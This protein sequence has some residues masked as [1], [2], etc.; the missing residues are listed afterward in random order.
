MEPNLIKLY[1][2]FIPYMEAVALKELGFNEPCFGTI[3]RDEDVWSWTGL[4]GNCNNSFPN[5]L[6]GQVAAPLYQQ[7]FEFFREKYNLHG[8]VEMEGIYESGND[9]ETFFYRYK[10]NEKW[11]E[12]KD[13]DEDE[14][15]FGFKHI[16]HGNKFRSY[17]E[18]QLNCLKH[19]IKSLEK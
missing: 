11:A 1:Q 12:G 17:E 8:E 3:G 19:L 5:H 9:T 7:A 10:I 13:F 16:G 2:Q 4:W 15:R 14:Y 6:E 18:A